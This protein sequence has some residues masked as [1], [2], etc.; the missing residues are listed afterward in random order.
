MF[1]LPDWAFYPIASL[2]VGGMIF[3][4]LSSG[5]SSTRLPGDILEN[6][7]VYDGVMLNSITLGN[8]LNANVMVENNQEFVRIDAVRGPFD[9]PQ[10]AGA[11]FTLTPNEI[12][13]IQSHVIQV[14]YVA[15]S[16]RENGASSS[17]FSFF[18]PGIG[19]DSWQSFPVTDEF[20]DVSVIVSPPSCEWDWSYI[21]IWPD[22]TTNAN[23]I[24]V[25]S[26]KIE[27]LE[28]AKC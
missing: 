15:R 3:G 11:F 5:D 2:F 4:A 21:G 23:S 7:I 16:S 26:V 8:G 22:W 6:G 27:A 19:Q 25:Q 10:S 14:T 9:G 18:V 20:S 28:P 24:D 1:S 12:E 17:N 13:A